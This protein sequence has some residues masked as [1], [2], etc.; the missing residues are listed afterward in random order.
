MVVSSEE[1]IKDVLVHKQDHFSD[2]PPSF[3][4]NILTEGRSTLFINDSARFRFKKNHMM[5]AMKLHGDGLKHLEDITL[6][7]GHGMLRKMEAYAGNAFDPYDLVRL[8]SGE[9]LMALTYGYSTER[10]VQ[11][12]SKTEENTVRLMQATG[13][14]LMLDIFPFLRHFFGHM[15]KIYQELINAR[16][17][18]IRAVRTFTNVRKENK[19]QT[20]SKIFIDHFIYL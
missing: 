9:I 14:Y 16:D 12:F 20:K 19:D 3:R 18:G 1:T 6:S 5:R 15:Q 8:T 4:N 13:K 2:R 7:L 11:I 17:S 10:D